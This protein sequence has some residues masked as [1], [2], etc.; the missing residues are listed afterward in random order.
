M[1]KSLRKLLHK[2]KVLIQKIILSFYKLK[3]DI[4]FFLY[5]GDGISNFVRNMPSI[6]IPNLLRKYGAEIKE[7]TTIDSGLIL[8]RIKRKADFKKLKIG[9]KAHI[10]HNMVLDFSSSIEIG[11]DTAFGANCQIWTHTGNWTFNRND[12]K[13]IINPVV[14]GNAVI[15]YSGVIISQNV[16]I[17]NYVRVAAGSVVTKDI[18]DKIFAGG[19]PAKIIKKLIL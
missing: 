4:L 2:A 8:H 7:D 15:C 10:G 14:I 3:C 9:K 11:A 16:K 19:V 17:G 13:D 1:Y 18:S 5:G 6:Y 12:E